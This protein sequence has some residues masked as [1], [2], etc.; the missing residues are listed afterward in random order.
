MHCHCLID[1]F[2][3]P[4]R[5]SHFVAL[6]TCVPSKLPKKSPPKPKPGFGVGFGECLGSS[7]PWRECLQG[8]R[9]PK[10]S[11]EDTKNDAVQATQITMGYESM[12]M[13]SGVE[14]VAGVAGV[15]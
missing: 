15:R 12:V 8:L 7:L 9:E 13:N 6:L 14:A 10:R 5:N 2:S 4:K 3:K 1:F 11:F